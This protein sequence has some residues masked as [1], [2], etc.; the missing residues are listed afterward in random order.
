MFQGFTIL[1]TAAAVLVTLPA[2]AETAKHKKHTARHKTHVVR[3]ARQASPAQWGGNL[4]PTG[5]IY[6]NGG[7]YM[8]TDPDPFIRFQL[9]R[10]VSGRLGA[11]SN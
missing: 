3:L 10:D 6:Y 4:F 11:D 2:A 1:A 9:W 7:L 8:G 5:P